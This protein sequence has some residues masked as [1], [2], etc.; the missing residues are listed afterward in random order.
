MGGWEEEFF[1]DTFRPAA[2]VKIRS[3]IDKAGRMS[4]WDYHV[5][6]AGQRG[7]ENFYEIPHHRE[8]VHGEW[9]I[10]PGVHPFAVGPWRAPAANTNT[11]AR[12][13]QI[14]LMAAK[15]GKDPLAFHLDQRWRRTS[16]RLHGR[17]V[18]NGGLRRHG[19]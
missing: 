11:Y 17:C 4:F 9:R 19:C 2:V 10:G 8:A 7:C 12:D 13:L 18:G 6:F 16:H 15:A 3:G 1:F 14:N 5:Y